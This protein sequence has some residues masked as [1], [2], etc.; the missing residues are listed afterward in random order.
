MSQQ[1]ETNVSTLAVYQS[2][3]YGNDT[4]KL[5][6]KKETNN[7]SQKDG[8]Q[9]II[10]STTCENTDHVSCD[11][12]KRYKYHGCIA[13]NRL[14]SGLSYYSRL[15]IINNDNDRNSFS[16]FMMEKYIRFIDDYTH[17]VHDHGHEIEHIYKA[18]I[19]NEKFTPCNIKACSF[20]SRHYQISNDKTNINR[21]DKLDSILEFFKTEMDSLH[22]YLYHLF[23]I[24]FRTFKNKAEYESEL[25]EEMVNQDD[26]KN[27]ENKNF[28]AELVK[29]IRIINNRKHLSAKFDRI[30][31]SNKFNMSAF[32][33]KE[34][35][36]TN[37]TSTTY[38]DHL[39]KFI[40]KQLHK[41]GLSSE[42]MVKLKQYVED[43]H[44]DS[45]SI[46]M[47]VKEVL[48]S[49]L[50][51]I[52]D[53]DKMFKSLTDF[54]T[55]NEIKSSGFQVGYT[56]YYWTK[57]KNM[58]EF[59]YGNKWNV[60]H[61]AGYAVSDLYVNQ[62][63]SS[64][65]EEISNYKHL[66]ITQ[67]N[68]KYNKLTEYMKT[69]NARIATYCHDYL[70]YDIADGSPIS[71]HHLLSII[72][73]TDFSE[74]STDFSSTFRAIHHYE[75]LSSIKTRNSNYW[76]MSKYL[77]EAIECY[78]KLAPPAAPPDFN[79]RRVTLGFDPI[80]GNRIPKCLLHIIG[81]FN[82]TQH[83]MGPF[84]TGLSFVAHLPQFQI[85]LC[86]PTSTSKDIE[87]AANFSGEAGMVIE[88]NNNIPGHN[89]IRGF[90]VCWLS[91][92]K[93]E[94]EVLW[95]GGHHQMKIKSV[96]LI[97]KGTKYDKIFHELSQ[98]DSILNGGSGTLGKKVQ[99]LMSMKLDKISE[100]KK[101]FDDYTKKTFLLWAKSKKIII[102]HS[103]AIFSRGKQPL[104]RYAGFGG[105]ERKDSGPVGREGIEF[106]MDSK[107]NIFRKE[108]IQIFEDTENIIIHT[109]K[110]DDYVSTNSYC[111][112]S[113]FS[114]YDEYN[115][116]FLHLLSIVKDGSFNKITIQSEEQNGG[117]L[118]KLW[119]SSQL[120]LTKTYRENG[121][122]IYFVETLKK[123]SY[124]TTSNPANVCCVIV[125]KNNV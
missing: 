119:H 27:N 111:I 75:I 117:W 101:S 55:T 99:R 61:H 63:Y 86:S 11:R 6:E 4:L 38:L 39:F 10:D 104:K 77:R 45:V 102:L 92:F 113:R 37:D 46:V 14:I 90:D 82:Y 36:S 106:I 74:L 122:K 79:F 12:T 85:R 25:S 118:S 87:I 103:A 42:N 50:R 52:A 23:D 76:W 47:D 89:D 16:V 83:I 29:I 49:N 78:G 9:I 67:Y 17:L 13:L 3:V 84:F 35:A 68:K 121:L 60:H 57:Y 59:K 69:E 112:G 8:I 109:T 105:L 30:K 110:R 64:F 19:G 31:N 123:K 7:K 2:I 107:N 26:F 91:Q 96:H 43:E 44:F 53:N 114:G 71:K 54:V 95:F 98:I 5:R 88:L 70:Q 24:G 116:C 1:S 34:N 51:I 120:K 115:L 41:N 100:N 62:K 124:I 125:E 32:D 58:K 73:Y 18:M 40:S 20:T 65:K 72:L 48:N 22:F 93:S 81:F 97:K 80:T 94:S 21:S 56:F 28:D 66:N 33:V 15:D 108:L